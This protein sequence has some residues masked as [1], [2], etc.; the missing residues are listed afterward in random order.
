MDYTRSEMSRS[1][2]L[3]PVYDIKAM[4][5]EFYIYIKFNVTSILAENVI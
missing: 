3:I 4:N 1:V 5:V 2:Y